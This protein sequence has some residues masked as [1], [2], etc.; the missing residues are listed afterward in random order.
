MRRYLPRVLLA[1]CL[2]TA[3]QRTEAPDAPGVPSRPKATK[4][5]A[6]PGAQAEATAAP[7]RLRR[8][9]APATGTRTIAASLTID[10]AYALGATAG[11]IISDNGAGLLAV[12]AAAPDDALA[13]AVLDTA[14]G[15]LISNHGGSLIGQNGASVLSNH[16][17]TLVSN[18]A[19]NL[20][21]KIRSEAGG[22]LIGKIRSEN[23]SSLIGKIRTEGGGGL[24]GKIR[25]QVTQADPTPAAPA[26]PPLGTTAPAAGVAIRVFD[27]ATG[28]SVPLGVDEDGVEVHEVLTGAGGRFT[29]F[30]PANQ[31]GN[32]VVHAGVPDTDDRRLRFNLLTPP[33][34]LTEIVDEDTSLATHFLHRA[35]A[36]SFLLWID[37]L[38]GAADEWVPFFQDAADR[39]VVVDGRRRFK[40]EAGRLGIDRLTPAQRLALA[41]RM[42]DLLVARVD[43]AAAR[44]F[45]RS[46]PFAYQ[47]PDERAFDGL[48][49]VLR[50][51]RD[52]AT[53]RMRALELAGQDPFAYFAA[54]DYVKAAETRRGEPFEF[55]KPTDVV[56]FMLEAFFSDPALTP[57]DSITGLAALMGDLGVEITVGQ[58]FEAAAL[59]ANLSNSQALYFSDGTLMEELMGLMREAAP[60]P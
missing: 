47:G 50:A 9:L 38:P 5:P 7:I 19:S 30:P 27:L 44:L 58:R 43:P 39:Q 16:G 52:A 31:A 6:S 46:G 54:R 18:N 25:F 17:G 2:A 32:V 20:I 1:A 29:I 15:N 35:L 45:R 34:A 33:Q 28:A 36:R 11:R 3:C 53:T 23:G 51:V 42:V 60:K 13:E 22:S 8:L 4:P 12:G 14:G 24:I 26:A 59:G 55:K 21:G 40:A 41:E 48:V 49:A 10:A 57:A 37:P 56:D